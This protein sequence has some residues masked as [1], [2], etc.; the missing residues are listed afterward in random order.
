MGM[1]ATAASTGA[2]TSVAGAKSYE[3]ITVPAGE[4]EVIQ[5]GSGETFEN[6]LIDITAD[7][8]GLRILAQGDDW[9]IRNVGIKGQHDGEGFIIVP[10]VTSPDAHGLIENVYMGDGQPEREGG[11]GIWVNANLPHQG[12]ITI[13]RMH[14]AHMINNGAY[15]SGPGAQGA[16]G[17]TNFEDSYFYSNNISN[18]RTNSKGRTSYV[19]NCTVEVD[20]ST[21][22]CGENCSSP[23]AVN[24]RGVWSWYGT[25]KVID[26]DIQGGLQ[27]AHGGQ[28]SEENTRTGE[29]ADTTPPKGVPMTAEEAASGTGTGG[30]TKSGSES[31]TSDSDSS[32]SGS[33]SGNQ[34]TDGSSSNSSGSDS[35]KND[36]P[37]GDNSVDEQRIPASAP[38]ST[39]RYCVTYNGREYCF[40]ISSLQAMLGRFL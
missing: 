18:I 17:V 31:D 36:S 26:S 11:G 29:N 9:V 28:I 5:I 32:T 19:R 15:A 14:M 25:T 34:T 6:V 10:G 30:S 3:T 13:R 2:A 23:G 33:D 21:P 20:G 38:S 24:D 40:D 4:Q 1:A 39:D 22:P 37:A 16:N 27:T 7:G 12:T 8:A 35:T